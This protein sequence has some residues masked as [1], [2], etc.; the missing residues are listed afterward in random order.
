[1]HVLRLVVGALILIALSPPLALFTASLVPVYYVLYKYF[2]SRVSEASELERR[3]FSRYVSVIG[4]QLDS[5][6]L[7]KRTMA[8]GYAERR[9]EERMREWAESYRRLNFYKVVFNQ[10]Y[11]WLY[12]M[13]VTI[14][15]VA[16]GFIAII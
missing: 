4:E 9:M 6:D 15:L 3:E 11:S 12:G 10:T 16:G 7:F 14:I 2:S 8:F 13:M 1:M 5:Y